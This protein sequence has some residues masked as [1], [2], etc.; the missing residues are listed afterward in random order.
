MLRYIRKVEFCEARHLH[1]ALL[2]PGS[3]SVLLPD[4]I[5]WE[6]IP[7]AGLAALTAEEEVSDGERVFNTSLTLRMPCPASLAQRAA[8]RLTDV[9]GRKLLVGLAARPHPLHTQEDAM[10]ERPADPS[11]TTLRVTWTST[12][13]PLIIT[14]TT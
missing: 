6:E 4:P 5:A 3:R 12:L 11:Q 14:E 9:E 10:P 7:A 13:P 8:F 1:T 2:L